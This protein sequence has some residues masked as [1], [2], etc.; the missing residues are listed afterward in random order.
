MSEPHVPPL[1]RHVIT[2]HPVEKSLHAVVALQVVAG[3]GLIGTLL[4]AR[5][6]QPETNVSQCHWSAG[7]PRGEPTS[8]QLHQPSE[9]HTPMEQAQCGTAH[10][11]NPH[12]PRS[13]ELRFDNCADG[14]Q[15]EPIEPSAAVNQP[16]RSV[17]P[18]ERYQRQN[19]PLDL[20]EP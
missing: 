2:H 4:V 17:T 8:N 16:H 11:V 19:N 6:M 3:L 5:V 14:L 12:N 10:V 13:L 20:I 1:R 7:P 9:L 18:V 15:P